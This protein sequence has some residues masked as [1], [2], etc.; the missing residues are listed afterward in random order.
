M[1]WL[2]ALTV[3]IS[4]LIFSIMRNEFNEDT[5]EKSIKLSWNLTKQFEF[6]T[7]QFVKLITRTY[8]TDVE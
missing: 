7:K 3:Y 8:V 2:F 5:I 6:S 1:K 4:M